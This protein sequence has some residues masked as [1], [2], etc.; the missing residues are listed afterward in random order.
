MLYRQMT[1]CAVAT[2]QCPGLPGRSDPTSTA[3]VHLPTSGDLASLIVVPFINPS[4]PTSTQLDSLFDV[5]LCQQDDH[6][7]YWFV[8]SRFDLTARRILL[9]NSASIT[10]HP[11]LHRTIRP[12][13]VIMPF[14]PSRLR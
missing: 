7:P 14:P 10:H 11:L 12:T 5:W 4:I 2:S 6:L 9:G 13:L 8:S 1:D 3:I